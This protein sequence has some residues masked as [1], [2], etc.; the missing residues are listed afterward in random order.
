MDSNPTYTQAVEYTANRGPQSRRGLCI[1]DLDGDGR[2]VVAICVDCGSD[3][4]RV[5]RSGQCRWCSGELLT[6]WEAALRA[7]ARA[8]PG[9]AAAAAGPVAPAGA[10]AAGAA[11]YFFYPGAAAFVVPSAP[12]G[13]SGSVP[14]PATEPEPTAPLATATGVAAQAGG[15][16]AAVAP[17]L[18]PGSNA[19]RWMRLLA[20]VILWVRGGRPQPPRPAGEGV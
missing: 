4:H 14:E 12:G 3:W 5:P 11:Y 19:L 10:A 13:A 6:D 2:P 7:E 20:G 15:A 16:A 1:G 18:A 8:A 17:A 9:E